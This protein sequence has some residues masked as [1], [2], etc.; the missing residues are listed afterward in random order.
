MVLEERTA[1]RT[2]R[3]YSTRYG[4]PSV[5]FIDGRWRAGNTGKK[6]RYL[7]PRGIW[8][9]AAIPPVR[10]MR[11]VV[12]KIARRAGGCARIFARRL[13]SRVRVDL[14]P[15]GVR[16][17]GGGSDSAKETEIMRDTKCFHRF[18]CPEYSVVAGRAFQI[19][20]ASR[21]T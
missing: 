1:V 11:I 4:K 21:R 8:G 16:K 15:R 5:D 10:R 19:L 14:L 6:T 2:Q 9:R 12:T 13:L 7:F 18:F 20:D 3:E 17:W